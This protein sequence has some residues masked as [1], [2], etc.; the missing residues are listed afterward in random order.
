[1]ENINEVMNNE[2]LDEVIFVAEEIVPKTNNGLKIVG[3]AAAVLAV[4]FG[5]YKGVQW[6]G[7]KI[8]AKK[9]KDEIEATCE[10]AEEVVD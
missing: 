4:G 5:I 10:P 7:G 3:G 2:N 1:M 9:E 6:I 8:K